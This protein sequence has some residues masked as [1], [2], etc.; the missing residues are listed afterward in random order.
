MCSAMRHGWNAIAAR[1]HSTGS[2]S[3]ISSRHRAR[4]VFS[5]IAV[6]L[7]LG[8]AAPAQAIEASDVLAAMA[9]VERS[10][11]T[12]EETRYIGAL[13]APLVRRGRLRYV[14]PAE[15]EVAVESPVREKIR[16]V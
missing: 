9:R 14:R 11:A 6:A 7:T 1:I 15:L 5:V 12:F 13:T 2:T 8:A 4:D 16:I 3:M 10:E